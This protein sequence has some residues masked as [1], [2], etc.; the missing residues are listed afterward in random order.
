MKIAKHLILSLALLF[1]LASAKGQD[2]HYNYD[3]GTNF[4]SYR[5]YQWVDLQRGP[6]GR[7]R[8]TSRP[9]CRICRSAHHL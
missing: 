7:H 8:P 3:R 9:V 2:I 6:G 5:T 4:Q 1:M